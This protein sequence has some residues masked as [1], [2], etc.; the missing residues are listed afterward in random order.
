VLF[1]RSDD[2]D[3]DGN[4][5]SCDG[6]RYGLFVIFH[7]FPCILLISPVITVVGWFN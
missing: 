4:D 3:D 5:Y 1:D 6:S 2:D 7:G